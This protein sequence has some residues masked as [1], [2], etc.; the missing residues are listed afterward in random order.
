[1]TTPN[2]PLML[3]VLEHITA[4]PDEHDQHTWATRAPH[5]GTTYCFAGWAVVLTGH[6]VKWTPHGWCCEFPGCKRESAALTT[7]RRTIHDVAREELGLTVRQADDMFWG[8]NS[9]RWLW[10][11]A[12]DITRGEIVPPPEFA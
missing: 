3:K 4:H 5:C 12:A 10:E 1:M 6:D 8:G 9:L 7:D 2:V 11:T